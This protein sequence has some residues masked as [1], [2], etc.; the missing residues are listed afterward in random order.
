MKVTITLDW[1]NASYEQKAGWLV[2]APL[3]DEFI[4]KI[5]RDLDA[6]QQQ[7]CIECQTWGPDLVT[8]HWNY[9]LETD[10]V[11]QL[12]IY[13]KLPPEFITSI[14][15][16]TARYVRT[17]ILT[18]QKITTS[19][20]EEIWDELADTVKVS[21]LLKQELPLKSIFEKWPGLTAQQRA[22]AF[23]IQWEAKESVLGNTELKAKTFEF[24]GLMEQLWKEVK[25]NEEVYL[26]TLPKLLT[27]SNELVRAVATGYIDGRMRYSDEV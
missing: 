11:I 1:E 18:T 2:F 10:C 8:K 24:L 6:G 20:M 9:I 19:L 14:W 22:A 15:T 7:L 5:F 3:P 25:T 27:H 16:D 12:L 21:V 4:D 17:S 13:Q 26:G 23:G